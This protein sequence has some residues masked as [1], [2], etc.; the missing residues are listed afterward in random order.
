MADYGGSTPLVAAGLIQVYAGA[1][2]R[3]RLQVPVKVELALSNRR[4][5]SVGAIPVYQK[6]RVLY[7]NQLLFLNIRPVLQHLRFV[8]V[9][10]FANFRNAC[11]SNETWT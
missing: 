2:N 3:L 10:S 11:C 9:P 8:H 4:H 6:G 1:S 7:G 5:T